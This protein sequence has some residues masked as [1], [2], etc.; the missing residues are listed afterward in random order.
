LI[1]TLKQARSDMKLN[2]DIATQSTDGQWSPGLTLRRKCD[3]G[4]HTMGG[5]CDDCGKKKGS[6]QRKSSSGFESSAVPSIVHEVLRSPGQPLDPA[7]RGFMEPRFRHDFS[8]VRVHTDERAADS[9]RAVDSLAYTV[10]RNIVF[11][12]GRYVPQTAA[13][14]RLLA[15]ELTH[16]VQQSSTPQHIASNLKI[17]DATDASERAADAAAR[18]IDTGGP[19]PETTESVGGILHRRPP[20][21]DDDPIHGPMIEDF[22]RRAGLPESGRD[23]SGQR[24]GPSEGEIKYVLSQPVEDPAKIRIDAVPDFLASSLTATRNVN[25]TVND[26]RI[27]S[28]HWSLTGPGGASI[29]SS[30]TTAGQP[31]ATSQPFSLQ[32]AQFSGAGF[33]AGQYMLYCYGQDQSGRSI[34]YARRDFNVLSADLTTGTA[35][36]TTYGDLTFTQYGATNATPVNPNWSIHATLQ[37]LPNAQVACD[38]IAFIQASQAINPSGQSLMHLVNPQILARQTSLAWSIDQ[39]QGNISPYYIAETHPVTGVTADDP[40]AGQAGSGT[41]TPRRAATLIDTPGSANIAVNARFESCAVCRSGANSGQV[42]GCATWGFAT[43]VAGL[44]TL[45]PRSFRQMP[46]ERFTETSEAWNTWRANQPAANRP[47]AIP[48]LRSP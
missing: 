23:E 33:V 47:L 25:V 19:V 43:D 9:A 3:C 48:A 40:R 31:N 28:L 7:T 27:V 11:D 42:Y 46:S 39:T 30:A 32:P 15:H 20:G 16:V 26:S 13:G 45:M 17:S 5:S 21:P 29:A 6:L 2:A 37:F 14:R 12:A 34:I 22:R 8:H 36:A 1:G 18:M 41:S 35:R 38:D 4:N 24:V 10:G 44:V